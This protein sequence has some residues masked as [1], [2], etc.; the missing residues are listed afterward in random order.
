ME[1]AA[2]RKDLLRGHHAVWSPCSQCQQRLLGLSHGS[3]VKV[4]ILCY[5][6][7]FAALVFTFH[8]AFISVHI[9]LC[10]HVL[11]AICCRA[12]SR[13]IHKGQRPR[14]VQYHIGI[15]TS[16]VRRA[17]TSADV[18]I[19]LHGQQS[20]GVKHELNGGPDVFDR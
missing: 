6:N 16:D 5:I 9:H 1:A 2:Q 4:I 19:T 12:L 15:T 8:S 14:Q 20:S 18:Y 13:E 10:F 17:G 3:W 7:A 11:L